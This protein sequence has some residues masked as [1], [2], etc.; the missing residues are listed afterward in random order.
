MIVQ[1][2]NI[3]LISTNNQFSYQILANISGKLSF[4]F[5]TRVTNETNEHFRYASLCPIGFLMI[6]ITSISGATY[7]VLHSLLTPDS[8]AF[9]KRLETGTKYQSRQY[10]LLKGL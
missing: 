2:I 3:C 5:G 6:D 7:E 4:L 8:Q 10:A 1:T 9:L